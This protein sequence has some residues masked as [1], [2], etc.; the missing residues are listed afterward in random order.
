M[1]LLWQLNELWYVKC[2]E[3]LL[4]HGKQYAIAIYCQ[5]KNTLSFSLSDFIWNLWIG[6]IK[7]SICYKELC[8]FLLKNAGYG[9]DME[10]VV[11]DKEIGI[12]QKCYP[13]TPVRGPVG[14][15]LSFFWSIPQFISVFSFWIALPICPSRPNLHVTF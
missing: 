3:R 7:G 13:Q 1:G 6:N 4:A 9:L 15:S 5:W 2:L 8:C 11:L 12:T 10:G 14:R